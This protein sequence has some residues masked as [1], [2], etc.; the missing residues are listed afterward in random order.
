M[1]Y[2]IFVKAKGITDFNWP[3]FEARLS[4]M[5]HQNATG[6]R[7]GDIVVILNSREGYLAVNHDTETY[8]GWHGGPTLAESQVP[9]IFAMPGSQFVDDNG[10]SIDQP[11]G[12]VDGFDSGL[13]DLIEQ[14]LINNDSHLRNWHFG[15]LLKGVINEFRE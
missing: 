15:S 9:M 4:E 12:L 8:P 6:S 3:E 10:N 7:T 14:G 13:Q 1:S 5:N 11:K 2:V